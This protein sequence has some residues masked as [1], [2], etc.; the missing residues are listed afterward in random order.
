MRYSTESQPEVA[1]ADSCSFDVTATDEFHFHGER[2]DLG[3]GEFG[4][5][6]GSGLA[7]GGEGGSGFAIG[8]CGLIEFRAEG[9]QDLVAIF[10][11]SELAG[12]VFCQM[13]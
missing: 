13:R 9:L 12:H 1:H 2:V 6:G 11:F 8:R 10:D 5:F 7:L 4:E 3:F